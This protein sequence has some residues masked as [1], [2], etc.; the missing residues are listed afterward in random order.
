MQQFH[1]VGSAPCLPIVTHLGLVELACTRSLSRTL[2]PSTLATC[3]IYPSEFTL[4]A[5]HI[6]DFGRSWNQHIMITQRLQE[7]ADQ[8]QYAKYTDIRSEVS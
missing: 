8:L 7:A 2:S 5:D 6:A 4:Y 3:T 1:S